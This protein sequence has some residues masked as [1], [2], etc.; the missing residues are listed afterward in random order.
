MDADA[1]HE[2]EK[3]A[4]EGEFMHNMIGR[5][6][7]SMHL[8][9]APCYT[10]MAEVLGEG[11]ASMSSAHCWVPHTSCFSFSSQFLSTEQEER[12]RPQTGQTDR[13]TG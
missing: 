10:F 8:G 13:K 12:R 1:A 6:Q 2:F 11:D 4:E 9:L 3:V 7:L 5:E